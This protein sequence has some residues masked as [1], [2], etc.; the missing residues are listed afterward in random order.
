VRGGQRFGVRMR[1]RAVGVG[2]KAPAA[3]GMEQG[4]AVALA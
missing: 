4:I 1:A 2:G 3:A